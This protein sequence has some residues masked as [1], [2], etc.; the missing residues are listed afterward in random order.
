[1]LPR[2]LLCTSRLEQ[3]K[4]DVNIG[5]N[6]CELRTNYFFGL[7]DRFSDDL[8]STVGWA[9]VDTAIGIDT[10][11]IVDRLIWESPRDPYQQ[12][13]KSFNLMR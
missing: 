7:F 1:M 6:L 3:R 5:Q 2:Y 10:V 12:C 9:Q 11:G 8:D 4:R 13:V